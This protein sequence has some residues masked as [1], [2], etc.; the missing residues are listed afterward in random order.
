MFPGCSLKVPEYSIVHIVI[1]ESG[2][3]LD[4]AWKDRETERRDFIQT[5]QKAAAEPA[6]DEWQ[7]E[8]IVADAGTGGAPSLIIIINMLMPLDNQTN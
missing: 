2:R 6:R 7:L 8:T 5:K 3:V 4:D 1:R